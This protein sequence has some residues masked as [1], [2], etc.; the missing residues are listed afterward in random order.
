MSGRTTIGFGVILTIAISLGA[1]TGASTAAGTAVPRNK[2][3]PAIRGSAQEGS[4]LQADSG[5]WNSRSAVAYS[6]QWRRCLADGTGCVD[7]PRATDRIYAPRSDDV[8]HTLRV[9]VTASN[10]DGRSSATSPAIAAITALPAQAPHNTS[11]PAISGSASPGQVLTLTPG[12][13]TGATPI[14][15][16][17]RWRRCNATGGECDTTSVRAPTY[18]LSAA[19]AGHSL[20]TLV[21]ATNAG[22]AAASLTDPSPM[23]TAPSKPSPS[24]PQSTSSPRIFG[25]PQ[26]GQSLKGDRG[27]WA[28]NPTAFGYAWL[29]CDKAGAYCNEIGGAHGTT[30]VLVSADVGHT[31]SLKVVAKNA[32][33]NTTVF[34]A[35]TALVVAA[36]VSKSTPPANTSPPTVSGTAQEGK[37]LTGNR[38]SW[39]NSPTDYDYSWRRCDTQGN[40]CGDIG[41]ANGTTY[42]LTSADV[43]RTIRFRV[44]AK[45]ADGSTSATSAPTTV[46]KAGAKP[47]SSSPPTISGPPQEGKTL[48]G[49]KGTWTHNPT[50][51]D[52]AW[53]RCDRNGGSCAAIGGAT[54]QQYTLKSVDVGNTLRFRV[55]AKNSEGSTTATSV[56]TAVIQKAAAPPPPTP[57]RGNGCP[58]GSGNPDQVSAITSP[59]N[60]L[61]D[62]QTSDPAVVPSA[63]QTLVV[64]YHVASTCGGPVQGALI[65]ATAT[66]F[67]QFSIPPETP[68]GADGWATLV[69]QRLRGFPVSRHQQLIAMFVRA[70]KPGESVLAGISARRLFSIRVNLHQ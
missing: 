29:R 68:T 64:R 43:G 62:G 59:A 56:P 6:Y 40:N 39:S 1:F 14:A 36:P 31:I 23:V 51:Y 7:V 19:D 38:G 35:P 42:P 28:N 58:T 66:P 26:Q 25:T 34:S 44:T 22:G 20:R 69:F 4:V 11:L 61:I 16:S 33:G 32:G 49:N 10:N 54:S 55:T 60:L 21:T 70:R 41:G 9:V 15:F 12:T 27:Q 57:S 17:F 2:S 5:R 53:L 3:L 67:N 52:D 30:Y 37:T 24:R 47:E 63:V 48:T 8:G 65:Y 46:V 18:K 13:W 50:D 45:N